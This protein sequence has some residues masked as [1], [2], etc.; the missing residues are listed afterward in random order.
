LAGTE[1]PKSA[2]EE[3]LQMWPVSRKVNRVGNDGDPTLIDVIQWI[4][5]AKFNRF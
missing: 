3:M 4:V 5:A 1:L 2:P